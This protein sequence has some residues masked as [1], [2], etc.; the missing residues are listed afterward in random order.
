[1]IE[2]RYYSWKWPI[3]CHWSL[4]IPPKNVRKLPFISNLRF[5]DVFRG[6][7]KW[8]V[9]WNGLTAWADFFN[10]FDGLLHY[11]QQVFSI[12]SN[13][14]LWSSFTSKRS[15]Y[16]SKLNRRLP[17]TYI[18]HLIHIDL[19]WNFEFQSYPFGVFLQNGCF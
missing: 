15:T 11:Q 5:S 13:N 19:L 2:L 16:I 8:S 18:Q 1:M 10:L 6:Y 4:I 17:M 3:S 9:T 14:P 12:A 7:I